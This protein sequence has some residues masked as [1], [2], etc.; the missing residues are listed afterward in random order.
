MN[1]F[2]RAAAALRLELQRL[3]WPKVPDFHNPASTG[4]AAPLSYDGTLPCPLPFPTPLDVS[5]IVQG[6]RPAEEIPGELHDGHL[7]EARC[8][9]DGVGDRARQLLLVPVEYRQAVEME[10][11]RLCRRVVYDSEGLFTW[12]WTG[13]SGRARAMAVGALLLWLQETGAHDVQP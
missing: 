9:A 5:R 7:E 13:D 8:R 1:G 2:L 11:N 6:R 12:R 4:P 3:F 10:V